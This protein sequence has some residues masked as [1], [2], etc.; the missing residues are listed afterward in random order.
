VSQGLLELLTV[1]AAGLPGIVAAW[2]GYLATKG[3]GAIK[4]ELVTGND[5]TVG[6][7]VTEAHGKLS[8]QDTDFMTHR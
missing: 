8:E 5:K 1:I 3:A 7:M 2:F 4:H 6:E